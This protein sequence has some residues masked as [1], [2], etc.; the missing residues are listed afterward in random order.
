MVPGVVWLY[1]YLWSFFSAVIY[2]FPSRKLFVIGVTGTKGKSTTVELI[3]FILKQAGKKTA[4]IASTGMEVLGQREERPDENNTMPGRFYLQHF[5]KKA[6]WLGCEFA[7]VEV[8]SEGTKLNRHRFINWSAA[9]FLNLHPEHIERHGSFEKYREAKVEFFEYVALK[10]KNTRTQE[11]KNNLFFINKDD[12]NA[13]YFIEA[14]K[15]GQ[16]IEFGKSELKSK[17]IG[18]FNKYNIGAAA[19]MCKMLGINEEI[20]IKAVAEFKGVAGRMEFI[21]KE[22]FSVVVD[23][24]HTPDSL[25]KVYETLRRDNLKLA[26][27]RY[28]ATL[29]FGMTSGGRRLICVLGSAGGGRDKWKRPEMGKIAAE[30]CDE[31]VLTNEDPYNEQPEKIID[32]IFSGCSQTLN[33]KTQTLNYKGLNIYKIIERREAIKKAIDLAKENDVVVITGK[34]SEKWIHVAN[35]KKIPW[36]DKIEVVKLLK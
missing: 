22:P 31:I 16:V 6:A 1:H 15:G 32:N 23:Y 13:K 25:R 36:S 2:G 9:V 20:I 3:N 30:F 19:E 28:S 12:E 7:V 27:P 11:H 5:F 29:D 26:D 18:E 21:K 17:L 4:M 8:T 14:A 10:H 33:S 35:G 24:A 34:G